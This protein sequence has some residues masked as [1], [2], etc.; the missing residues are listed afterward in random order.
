MSEHQTRRCLVCGRREN[1]WTLA[2]F[3]K[4]GERVVFD[5][6]Q[7]EEGRGVYVH[8]TPECF[9]RLTEV[10][11]WERSL[12]RNGAR[13]QKGSILGAVDDARAVLRL[14]FSI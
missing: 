13:V 12:N 3:A 9:S 14:E 10:R 2:R 1:K 5:Q 6:R 4:Q 8:A 11:L 7:T